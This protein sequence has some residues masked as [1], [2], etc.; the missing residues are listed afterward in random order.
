MDAK[1][2]AALPLETVEKTG[3]A[4]APPHQAG[5]RSRRG[6][7][8]QPQPQ[9]VL[10]YE[11]EIDSV[12]PGSFT[13]AGQPAGCRPR[14]CRRRSAVSRALRPEQRLTEGTRGAPTERN[15]DPTALRGSA[16]TKRNGQAGCLTSLTGTARCGAACRVVWE[17]W[18]A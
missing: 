11:S 10:A 2:N 9:R 8:R 7:P 1:E 4:A 14:G 18:Q 15:L 16:Q 13:P 3:D 5:N 6:S 12:A 17:G